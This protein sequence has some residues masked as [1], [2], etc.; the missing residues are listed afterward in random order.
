[1]ET[2]YN[3][4]KNRSTWLVKLHLDNTSKEISNRAYELAVQANTTKQFKSMLAGLLQDPALKALWQEDE[5]DALQIDT[6][7][8]W[9]ALTESAKI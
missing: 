1:M 9:D 5:F 6:R 3:G 7:A 8:I 2:T 4:W